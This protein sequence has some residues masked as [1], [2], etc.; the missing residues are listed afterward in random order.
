VDPA[1]LQ[2][3]VEA[4]A[5]M[6]RGSA[7]AGE[8]ASAEWLARR[9]S[10]IG[11]VDVR[12][13]TF[14]YSRSF[15]T[16][17]AAHHLAGAAGALAGGPAGAALA[18][19]AAASY[20]LDF[21]GRRQW[22]R[23][24]LPAGEGTT[25]V[26]RIPA[27]GER[28]RTLVLVAHHDVAHT[29][30]IFRLLAAGRGGAAAERRGGVRSFALPTTSGLVLTAAGALLA[31]RLTRLLA[32]PLL[33]V[34]VALMADIERSPAVP[35]ASDNAT[36]VAGVLALVEEFTRRPLEGT[37]VLA[38]LPGCEESGMGGMAAWMRHEGAQLDPLSTLV[39]GLDT[40]GAGEPA[41][42][43]GEGPAR[44]ERYP[45]QVLAMADRGA[46]LAGLDPPR[47]WRIGGWTDPVLALQAGLPAL[48][49]VSTRDGG[50]TN[51]HLPTD[52]AD[53]VDWQSVELSVRLAE[54]TAR[55]FAGTG[56]RVPTSG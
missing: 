51:Y 15:A 36:G 18:L 1:A 38:V 53:R 40:L 37:E 54:G 10:G 26:G 56:L 4:L 55:D 27:A 52:T 14:R 3:D 34:Q 12:L 48:S 35:G 30:L 25:V 13:L 33:A 21:A 19:A 49:I 20:E 24:L 46:A 6:D 8:R 31:P 7:S 42:L 5:A 28:R 17:H 45:E 16:V 43:S 41:V 11:A 29:G 47:R 32:L 22:L 23:A 2:R 39:V 44:T 9:L 50:F